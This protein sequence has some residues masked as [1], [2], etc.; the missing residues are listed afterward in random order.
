MI[1]TL[2]NKSHLI[3]CAEVRWTEYRVIASV[4]VIYRFVKSLS[5][6]LSD[7]QII[8]ERSVTIIDCGFNVDTVEQ[9]IERDILLDACEIN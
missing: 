7:R 3:K 2:S 9:A 4:K 1:A 8:G 5:W 6:R